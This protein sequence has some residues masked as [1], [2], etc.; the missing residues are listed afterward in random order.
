MDAVLDLSGGSPVFSSVSR[1]N[2]SL[3]APAAECQAESRFLQTYD[4]QRTARQSGALTRVGLLT[5]STQRQDT[6]EF[7]SNFN[8][9]GNM[10]QS[11]PQLYNQTDST[12]VNLH[13]TLSAANNLL[14]AFS[15]T[16]L[17]QKKYRKQEELGR[18]SECPH[19]WRPLREVG[20]AAWGAKNR[21]GC[22]KITSKQQSRKIKRA[23]C[24]RPVSFFF[25]KAEN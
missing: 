4:A 13:C 12:G 16:C 20:L 19:F 18:R 23:A 6:L 14:T 11:A 5:N 3:P 9:L 8:L 10:N 24:S 17:Q 7:D 22:R 1:C 21:P 25:L 15:P 2:T